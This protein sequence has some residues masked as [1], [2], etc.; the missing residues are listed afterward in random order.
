MKY[1]YMMSGGYGKVF[2]DENSSVVCKKVPK[3]SHGRSPGQSPNQSPRLLPSYTTII[4]LALLSS[5]QAVPG[6]PRLKGIDAEEKTIAIYMKHHGDT[7][8]KWIKTFAN[9]ANINIWGMTILRQLIVTLLHLESAGII[10]T[11]I[12]P[13]NV[14]V[15]PNSLATTLIDFGCV[16]INQCVY[17]PRGTM[18]HTDSIGTF[19]YA[20]PE[21]IWGNTPTHKSPVWSLALLTCTLFASYPISKELTHDENGVWRCTRREWRDVMK[22]ARL[23]GTSLVLP[24]RV[25]AIIDGHP[26]LAPWV[27]GALSWDAAHR[28]SLAEVAGYVLGGHGPLRMPLPI[29][30]R[31]VDVRHMPADVRQHWIECYYSIALDTHLESHFAGAVYLL[32]AAGGVS[33]PCPVET[34][35]AACWVLVGML[36]N[37]VFLEDAHH[38]ERIQATFGANVVKVADAIWSV[39][40][41]LAWRLYTRPLDV[42]LL[43]DYG[44]SLA[45]I[46]L[47]DM[48]IGLDRPWSPS[49]LAAS[50]ALLP[51]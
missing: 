32:D 29:Y 8:S 41:Q 4:E 44:L 49:A 18:G 3:V 23:G 5:F 24:R 19:H 15:D 7:L 51:S 12:K 40:E 26:E 33:M 48:F 45:L 21:M 46:E 50:R 11:D 34:W 35:T 16:S 1:R 37:H 22:A 36:H 39:G 17:T 31:Q 28:P 20:A 14:L 2:V 13:Y 38:V 42:I 10:H 25:A 30:E 27:Y 47:R 6:M 43:Q 9:P